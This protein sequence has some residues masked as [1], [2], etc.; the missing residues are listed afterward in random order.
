[1]DEAHFDRLTRR[2]GTRRLTRAD[3]MSAVAAGAAALL[4]AG[5][6]LWV[7]EAG[8]KKKKKK[9]KPRRAICH[10][11]DATGQHCGTVVLGPPGVRFHLQ[12]HPF[13]HPGACTKPPRKPKKPKKPKTPK[14]TPTCI[15]GKKNGGE[16]GVDC[17][18]PCPRCANGQGCNSRTDCA[19]AFCSGTKCQAC[20]SSPECGADAAGP[21]TCVQPVGSGPTVCATGT[22][23]DAA[24]AACTNCSTGTLCVAGVTPG[25]FDCFRLCG[26]P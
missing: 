26:V 17:G 1:V 9:R 24:V 14:P 7:Q 2:I 16:T 21:C 25:T 15:D 4:G 8:A 5:G 18:G 12:H 23:T 11:P 10:C 6:G 22:P 3:M 20:T 13:D 19:G